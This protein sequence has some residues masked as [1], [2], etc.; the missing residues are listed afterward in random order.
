MKLRIFS[1]LSVVNIFFNPCLVE[2]ISKPWTWMLPNG[3]LYRDN[4]TIETAKKAAIF[5]RQLCKN[6]TISKIDRR[7]SF[8]SEPY[9]VSA[10]NFTFGNT[11]SGAEIF[12]FV[13][14][15]FLTPPLENRQ[16]RPQAQRMMKMTADD[17]SEIHGDQRFSIRQK[18]S[19]GAPSQLPDGIQHDNPDTL[20]D[21][22]GDD[23]KEGSFKKESGIFYCQVKSLFCF[24]LLLF[25]RAHH[26]LDHQ[27]KVTTVL[28]L[29]RND[30]NAMRHK[31]H[32]VSS[33]HQ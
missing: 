24:I 8:G 10:K 3:N 33:H 25:C 18:Q 4:E 1:V 16:N 17:T 22:D 13:D 5:A 7:S 12:D 11:K 21:H 26:F 9:F 27:R 23:S 31:D 6:G 19:S 14:S 29:I 30:L 15:R 2:E 20:D 32:F 28:N